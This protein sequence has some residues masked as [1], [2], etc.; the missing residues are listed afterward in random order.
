MESKDVTTEDIS[1]IKKSL[2]GWLKSAIPS[3]IEEI[4]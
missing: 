1:E 3:R 2:V 4:L